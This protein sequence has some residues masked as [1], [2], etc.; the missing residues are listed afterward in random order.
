MATHRHTFIHKVSS[1]EFYVNGHLSLQGTE[2]HFSWILKSDAFI[3]TGCG[4]MKCDEDWDRKSTSVPFYT[5]FRNL[6]NCTVIH[7]SLVHCTVCTR[8]CAHARWITFL[9]NKTSV[10]YLD[11]GPSFDKIQKSHGSHCHETEK[12][13]RPSVYRLVVL[14]KVPKHD[15][16][17]WTSNV[18]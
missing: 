4:I 18:T 1:V 2:I 8:K 7:R 11:V 14:N 13:W 9:V 3:Q 17:K 5:L 12:E 15:F 10:A 16:R 6:V